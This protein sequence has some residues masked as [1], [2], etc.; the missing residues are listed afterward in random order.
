MSDN[1]SFKDAGGNTVTHAS[2]DVGSGVQ[3]S[4]H[5][6]VDDAGVVIAKAEDAAHASGDKG[7]MLLAVRKDT[8]AALAGADGDY[9]PLIV[10]SLGRLHV[11]STA[12]A[13]AGDVAHDAADSGNP[14][15]IGGKAYLDP[16][17][18]GVSVGDRVEAYFDQYGRQV[19]KFD[20]AM[21]ERVNYGPTLA[22][23]MALL[24]EVLDRSN[25][26]GSNTTDAAMDRLRLGR[27]QELIVMPPT[28]WLY[29]TY[30]SVDLAADL[31]FSTT[32][33]WQ[34]F[35]KV[36]T[37]DLTHSGIG[38][39]AFWLRFPM[40]SFSRG[41]MIGLTSTLNTT[42]NVKLK[43]NIPGAST[44]NVV[45]HPLLDAVDL[46]SG[47]TVWFSGFSVADGGAAG[48]RYVPMLNAPMA[49]CTLELLPAADPTSGG[50]LIAV[51][52]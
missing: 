36:T 25:G 46:S 45:C 49:Y 16:P 13:A 3:A 7:Y 31:G 34:N 15:K 23:G 6:P 22:Y 44:D 41:C 4:K 37:G 30:G 51:A 11:T 17:V 38:A 9:I 47:S 48:I 18:S 21:L 42:L 12:S 19:V 1:Y 27:E 32:N 28:R 39:A 10:D 8:A 52:R 14:V 20:Q 5:V 33:I 35:N 24:G 40:L 29:A 26:D 2:K 43:A 50:L